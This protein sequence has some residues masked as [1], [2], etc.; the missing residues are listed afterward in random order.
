M[1]TSPARAPS[2]R[3]PPSAPTSPARP[4][5][6]PAAAPPRARRWQ[7]RAAGGAWH[8]FDAGVAARLEAAH[9]AGA[10]AVRFEILGAHY[11]VVLVEWRQRCLE[12]R[13]RI[14]EVRHSAEDGALAEPSRS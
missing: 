13:A 8:D 5:L 14:R 10:V 2:E 1:P 12:D 7:H 6:E 9:A 4:A 11:E 3:A